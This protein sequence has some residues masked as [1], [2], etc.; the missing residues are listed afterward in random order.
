MVQ[1]KCRYSFNLGIAI[2]EVS[3][4]NKIRV[5]CTSQMC[6]LSR[7]IYD[8]TIVETELA[9]NK[10]RFLDDGRQFFSS[11]AVGVA[12]YRSGAVIRPE[13]IVVPHHVNSTAE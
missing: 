1:N 12:I 6:I 3:P 4:R 8:E 10:C 7:R 2:I 13:F 9:G 5:M 11:V